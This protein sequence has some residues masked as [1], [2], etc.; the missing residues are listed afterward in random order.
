MPPP[1]D[2]AGPPFAN[3]L[4]GLIALGM[5]LGAA[6]ATLLV[7]ASVVFALVVLAPGDPIDL[8]PNGEAMRPALEARWG[9]DQP[10]WTRLWRWF[11]AAASGDLGVSLSVRPGMPVAELIAGP[12]RGSA[13]RIGLAAALAT[14]AAITLALVGPGTGKRRAFVLLASVPPVFLLAHAGVFAINEITWSLVQAGRVARPDWFALPDQASA[15]REALA[16]VCLAVGSGTLA[17][18][19]DELSAAST[20]IRTSP[21]AHATRARGEP[22]LPLLGRHLLPEGFAAL[23]HRIA[24]LTGGVVVIEKLLL[25]P[26]GG[27]LLW[28]A[29]L[30]RDHDVVLAIAVASAS[31][32][33]GVQLLAEIVRV[34]MDPRSWSR[35]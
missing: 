9:L 15:V 34:A 11:G 17:A 6:A 25:I 13:V 3:A 12:L 24:V 33:V 35:R 18:L 28:N 20:R 2:A 29:A 1:S 22:L 26:G 7:A 19:H 21:L 8:L 5:R 23:A 32:V 31:L 16:V 30:A 10:L 27:A 14:G 4:G